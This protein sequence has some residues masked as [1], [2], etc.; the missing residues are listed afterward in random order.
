MNNKT[1]KRSLAPL[2][3]IAAT[4]SSR[5]W[6]SAHKGRGLL[7]CLFGLMIA[8]AG[9]AQIPLTGRVLMP[10]SSGVANVNV[11][12]L[13]EKF[14]TTASG[15]FTFEITAAIMK[16]KTPRPNSKSSPKPKRIFMKPFERMRPTQP[17][18][19]RRKHVCRI[20]ITNSVLLI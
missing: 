9:F 10:A 8:G 5:I 13:G 15:R 12:L 6:I 7:L 11:T 19:A 17:R 4:T 2:W 20:C 1:K 3:S 14:Q 16:P 18:A